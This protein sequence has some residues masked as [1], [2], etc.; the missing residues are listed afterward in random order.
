MPSFMGYATDKNV[1]TIMGIHNYIYSSLVINGLNR[2]LD[3]YVMFQTVRK[4]H[5]ALHI[6]GTKSYFPSA[7]ESCQSDRRVI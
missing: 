6:D 2:H 4:L 5:S 3:R 7:V 1:I